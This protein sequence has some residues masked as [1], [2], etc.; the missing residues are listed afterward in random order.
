MS[1]LRVNT[2]QEADGTAF[3]GTQGITEADQWR[4]TS[5]FTGSTSPITSN[6]E[7]N[8]TVFTT[9]GSG[10][11]QSSGVFTFPSTGI[12]L[13][14]HQGCF[15]YTS[16]SNFLSTRVDVTTDGGSNWT[17]RSYAYAYINNVT[18]T[19]YTSCSGTL[20]LDVTDT[21]Q[22]KVRLLCPMNNSASIMS[23]TNGHFTGLTFLKLGET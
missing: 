2:I 20:M 15:S 8:D 10:M 19:T 3:L 1:T 7:R 11:S 21:S 23:S 17:V 18:D 14:Q 12:Y 16:S 4:I 5:S 9:V 6:W 13:V 22:V